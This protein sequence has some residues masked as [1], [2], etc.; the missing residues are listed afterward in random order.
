MTSSFLFYPD[1]TRKPLDKGSIS[2]KLPFLSKRLEADFPESA[3]LNRSQQKKV[4]PSCVPKLL[5]SMKRGRFGSS[6]TPDGRA[7]CP[8][9][10]G[11]SLV[12]H[13]GSSLVTIAALCR[14]PGVAQCHQ[15]DRDFR[16]VALELIENLI[17]AATIPVC[18]R[19]RPPKS[20][21]SVPFEQPG[22]YLDDANRTV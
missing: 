21:R 16:L 9:V 10:V 2:N 17:V 7:C 12:T 8:A 14:L 22:N 4:L 13:V 18:T 5:R 6:V 3:V 1:S 20:F 11:F 19:L 15:L